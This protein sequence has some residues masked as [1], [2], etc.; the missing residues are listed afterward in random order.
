MAIEHRV[1]GA[2]DICLL[3]PD[4]TRGSEQA[5]VHPAIVIS[6]TAMNRRSR[7]MIVC[8]ITRNTAPW[9]TKI[10]L[11]ANC[12]TKGM[13][14]TDQVRAVDKDAR[15]L[16]CVETT[17]ADF[18]TLVRSFVGRLLDIEVRPE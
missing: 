16:R 6:T 12:R 11:P 5:G 14:L 15:I 8:P 4:P 13:V 17:P 3:D 18:V 10:V 7:R 1:V 2:G 9:T